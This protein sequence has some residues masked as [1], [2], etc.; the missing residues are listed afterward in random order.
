MSR[1]N[2][3]LALV[4]SALAALAAGPQPLGAA[5]PDL[6][7]I[8]TRTGADTVAVLSALQGA[9]LKLRTARCQALLD[10]FRG[11]D[12]LSLR[13]HLA[14]FEMEAADYLTQLVI[15]DG[16]ERRAGRRCQARDAA[17]VTTRGEHVVYV[18]GDVFRALSTGLRENV[19]IHEM[20]HTLGLGE[21]PPRPGEI[22]TQVWRRCGG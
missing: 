7:R 5:E 16:G 13:D 18:C 22:N 20:L 11:P 12:G 3:R 6:K 19:L 21:N 8:A 1:P 10:D 4:A 14:P 2:S 15:L 9:Q 17:A